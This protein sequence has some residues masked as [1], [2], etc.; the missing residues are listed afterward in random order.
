MDFIKD[1]HG[2][3]A[4]YWPIISTKP[5][6]APNTKAKSLRMTVARFHLLYLA[7][8]IFTFNLNKLNNEKL[9]YVQKQFRYSQ[10]TSLTTE[11]QSKDHSK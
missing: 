3:K 11:F 10:E 2:I 6:T 8:L 5:P 9:G 7:P 1:P 4:S